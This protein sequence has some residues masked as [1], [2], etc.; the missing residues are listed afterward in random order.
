[1][2]KTLQKILAI[3]GIGVVFAA[4]DAQLDKGGL[5]YDGISTQKI[6]EKYAQT[7]DRIKGKYQLDGN[8]LKIPAPDKNSVAVSLGDKTKPEFEPK[9][10]ITRWEGKAK[11]SIKPKGLE[12]IQRK[13]KDLIFEDD[14]IKFETPDITY[15]Y[16]DA[17]TSTEEGGYE[18]QLILNKKPATSTFYSTIDST[19]LEFYKQ[20]PLT[21]EEAREGETC[22]ETYC[23]KDGQRTRERPENVVNSYAVYYS[24]SGDYSKMGGY[25]F[26][27]GKFGH[28]YRIKA[29]DADENWIWCDQNIYGNTH[30]I[31]CDWNWLQN[32]AKYPV[33]I[34]P[35]IGNTNAGGSSTFYT[36]SNDFFCSSGNGDNGTVTSIS[37]YTLKNPN[38]INYKG[39]IVRVSDKNIITN[40]ISNSVLVN[41]TFQWWN[42]IFSTNPTISSQSYYICVIA[43]STPYF[44]YDYGS[45]YFYDS[46]NSYSS[47][48]NP[49]D[50][51]TVAN[52]NLSIYAT[53]EASATY[54]R[55]STTTI[56]NGRIQ[57][58]NGRLNIR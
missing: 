47:P 2:N 9:L 25:N 1:M 7:D 21:Q 27:A 18:Y 42:M 14:K 46:S 38:N 36:G 56:N 40:G 34:D 30:E 12:V 37:V 26:R 8:E 5:L 20:L 32:I 31:S 39:A 35:T 24:E 58:N 44:F 23:E 19:G 51:I 16:F 28:I 52:Q 53:Y 6:V 22:Y 17:P 3:L 10:E 49:T 48:T 55:N 11:F 4:G 57:I 50:G 54:S 33:K 29:I 13:D 45:S 41:S 43:D 15:E